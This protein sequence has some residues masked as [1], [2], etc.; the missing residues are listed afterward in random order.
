MADPDRAATY[1]RAAIA[2]NNFLRT[3]ESSVY[4]PPGFVDREDGLG[5]VIRDWRDE[6]PRVGS[7]R[8]VRSTCIFVRF[9][10]V[11]SFV[12]LTDMQRVLPTS[13]MSLK[14][15]FVPKLEK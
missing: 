6:V 7:N 11:V 10:D 15:T 3:T 9:N 1:T 5:N 2:L 4:C 12:L 14:I 13:M 8:C